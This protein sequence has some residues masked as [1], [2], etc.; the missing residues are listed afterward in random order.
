[1]Q[2]KLLLASVLIC[3]VGPV[4]AGQSG[5]PQARH[6]CAAQSSFPS[7]D[8]AAK[9]R[10]VGCLA[11]Q[12]GK[13]D[14]TD[15]DGNVYHLI[16]Y[17]SGLGKH[18]GDE[19]D[20]SGTEAAP[21]SR[22]AEGG[23]PES[24][25]SVTSWRVLLHPSTEGMRPTVSKITNL[26]NYSNATYGVGIRVPQSFPA[27]EN[28]DVMSTPNFVEDSGIVQLLAVE[29]PR[30]VYPDTNFVGAQFTVFVN[31]KIQSAET[32]KQFSTFWPPHTFSRTVH[33]V[34]YAQTLDVGVATGTEYAKYSL[35]TY[36][37]GLCYEFAFAMGEENPGMQDLPCTVHA[38]GEKQ[39][40]ELM[41]VLLSRVSYFKPENQHV[42]DRP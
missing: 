16:A 26:R 11:E 40:M 25:L 1:M 24:T 13:L 36:Q 35:H 18:V 3:S 29:M 19:L 22:S 23:S 42:P 21:L 20:V 30:D 5:T 15:K 32:C 27:L 31:P 2:I 6:R 7:A 28:S 37:N 14:L 33:G 39:E 41:D 12:S 34:L 38:L 10:V 9:V 17:S 4:A 8:A